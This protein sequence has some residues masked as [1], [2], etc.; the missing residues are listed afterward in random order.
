MT[1]IQTDQSLGLTARLSL[2]AP[3]TTPICD[4]NGI[5][6]QAWAHF[7]QQHNLV[8]SK[9]LLGPITYAQLPTPTKPPVQGAGSINIDNQPNWGTIA[10]VTDS[11]VNS[12]GAKITTGGGSYVV[13]AFCD[14]SFWRVACGAGSGGGGGGGSLPLTA[15]TYSGLGAPS[16]NEGN[17]ALVTDSPS[18]TYG[19]ILT[20]GGGTNIVLAYCTGTYWIVCG[21]VAIVPFYLQI[22]AS[23]YAGLP[24]SP[25][26]GDIAT[27]TDS[28]VNTWGASVTVGGGSHKVLVWY[29]GTNWTCIGV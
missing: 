18:P 25:S 26:Q 12:F 13:L 17:L 1:G 14:G 27:I 11:T 5:L 16:S 7:F 24:G 28:T 10:L 6:T 9:L 3:F 15:T 23:T 29:N 2:F 22:I 4:K 8:G 19:Y 20:V 21:G